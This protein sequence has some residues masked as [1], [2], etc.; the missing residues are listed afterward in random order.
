MSTIPI[1]VCAQ[2]RHCRVRPKP[3]LF[4]LADLQMP[5]VL[6][7][8]LEWDQQDQERRLLEMQRFEAGQPF[9]YE[10]YH[11]PWCAAYTP[12]DALL[13][14]KLAK[15]AAAGEMEQAHRA[16]R[17]SVERGRD[18]IRHAQAGDTAALQE[19]MENRRAMMNPVTG[20]VM[21][22]YALCAHMN[23][24]GQCLLYEPTRSDKRG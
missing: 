15:A 8:K 17:E 14:D 4:S 21:Q 6:K 12:F 7:S 5:G 11:Y 9:S 10:P 19:L 24:T 20:E 13:Q 22:V 18:L 16:A 1:A 2:C 3:E 23:P